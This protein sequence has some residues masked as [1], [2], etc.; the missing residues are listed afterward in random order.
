MSNGTLPD[1][2]SMAK[3]NP[4]GNRAPWYKNTAPTYAGIML[5]FVFWQDVPGGGGV[6]GGALSHGLGTALLGLIL[7]ALLCHFLYYLVPA[8]LGMKTGLPLYI[9]GTST[10]GATGG[11]IMPGFVMGLLQF[12]WLGVNSCFS[13]AFLVKP[14]YPDLGLLEVISTPPHIIVSIVWA[15]AAAF[16]GLKGIQ[17]VAKVAT[18]L[19]LIPLGI[20]VILFF[21]SVGGVGSFEPAQVG[22]TAEAPGLSAIGVIAM[23]LTYVIGF[24]ATAGAAGTDFGMNSRDS[25]DVSMGGLVGIAGATIF[26]GGLA[27][28]IVA[29]AFGSG[30]ATD[31]AVLN[32]TQLMGALI[33]AKTGAV[34]MWLL[35]LAAFPPACF[36]AFIA[37]NSFK[38]TLPKVNPFITVGIGTAV[39]ILLAVTGWAADVMSVFG[40]IGASFGPVCGAMMVDYI[41][42]GKKWAGPRAGWNPA[43]WISWIVGFIVGMMPLVSLP[44]VGKVNIPAAPLMAF[45]VGAVLYFA[46]SKAGLESKV[47]EMPAAPAEAAP[48]E[49]PAQEAPS[50]EKSD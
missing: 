38:T 47:L 33:G 20:L 17:Y 50:E 2:L 11:F 37:A 9:V 28:L 12:G 45:I 7:A 8:M 19:P 29:G 21:C 34:F 15:A 30:K 5:W 42:A 6:V 27:L 39:S 44:L 41:M 3:P 32:P 10:Y 16:M 23:L 36:S 22:V 14:F 31:A 24:F 4:L 49:A 46:L 25:K 48:P 18:Y 40:V 26:A 1:Y 35:A 43:G 13:A